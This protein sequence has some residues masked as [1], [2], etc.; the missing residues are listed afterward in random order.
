MPVII[1]S[2][3]GNQGLTVSLPVIEYAK[4]MSADHEKLIKE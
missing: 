1:N 4:E 3:S 2:G